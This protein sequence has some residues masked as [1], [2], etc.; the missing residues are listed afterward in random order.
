MK[1]ILYPTVLLFMALKLNA[2]NDSTTLNIEQFLSI[3]RVYHPIVRLSNI[4]IQKSSANILIAKGEFNPILSNTMSNKTFANTKY[5]NVI[6]PDITIPTWY[7]IEASLG[8]QNIVGNRLDASETVGQMSYVGVNVP[9]L[10]NLA[11][12]KRRAYLK[13]SKV[14]NEMAYTEQKALINTILME[15]ATQYWQWVNT[16]KIYEIIEKN[17]LNSQQR[18][19]MIKKTVKNGE[20]PALDTIEAL[21]QLQ[22]FEIQK[23]ESWYTFLNEGINLSSYLWQTNNLPYQLPNTIIPDND[24]E[25]ENVLNKF[26]LNLMELLENARELHPELKMYNQKLVVLDIEKKLKFQELLPKLDFKYN[27]LSKGNDVLQGKGLFFQDNFQYGLKFEMPLFLSK[28]RGEYKISK[29]KIE[30]TKIEQTQKKVAIELKIKNYYN[31]YLN[32]KTQIKIQ[33]NLQNNLYKM[34]QAE[35]TLF[36]NGESSMFLINSRENKLLEANRKLIETK[37]KFLKTIYALQWSAGLLN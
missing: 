12:D 29:L 10:K 8:T 1:K 2:Q 33:S 32:L 16:Y 21:T 14:Y 4:N 36:K 13:Q 3:V 26:Q 22:Y 27:H 15:A 20:R 23:N 17:Y 25:N 37:T 31:E 11:M 18:L 28:G 5:Y 24:W 19:D 7:G 35:E 30:E 34:L 6:N 9:L